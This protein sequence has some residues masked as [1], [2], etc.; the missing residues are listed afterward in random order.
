MTLPPLSPEQ[1]AAVDYMLHTNGHVFLTGRAGTGKTHALKWFKHLSS[2]NIH[3]CAPTGIAALN[4][5]GSTVHN[6]LG[7]NT[8]L[9]ADDNVDYY[10]V[11]AKRRHLM[12]MQ[13][14]IIDEISMVNSDLMD[15]IDRQLRVLKENR[16]EPFGGVQIVMIGDPYQLPPVVTKEDERYYKAC[17]YKS[18]WFFDAKIWEETDFRTFALTQVQ[19]QDDEFFISILNKVREGLVTQDDVN[20]LN[21]VGRRPGRT[22]NGILLGARRAQVDEHNKKKLRALK[23]R[24]VL[25]K[26]R[27]NSGFGPQIPAD[28]ELLLKP[29]AHIMMISNDPQDRW[30]NG[31]LG[32][33]RSCH[34]TSVI[35]DLPDKYG[36]I[37]TYNISATAWVKAG[38]L[39]EEYKDAPKFWQ[40]PMR[41]A[42]ASTVHKSQG[43]SLPEVHIDLGTGAF[44]PGQAYVALSRVTSPEGLFF[45][46]PLRLSDIRVDENVKRFFDSL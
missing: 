11:K 44:S 8:S 10:K 46:T 6:L 38:T 42:W 22:D 7:L 14:L 4:A 3:V 28:R 39:P 15:S 2:K 17:G 18:P 19:R 21:A 23:G 13:V 29:G 5:E 1:K 30:V 24:G 27:V 33:V 16:Y 26:A 45:D 35:V 34:E 32:H 37:F 40:I 9:P 25:Y 41:H 12:S 43:L 20:L 31:S 36:K